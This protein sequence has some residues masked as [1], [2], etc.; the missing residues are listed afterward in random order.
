MMR[1]DGD[2]CCIGWNDQSWSIFCSAQG[3]TAWHKNMPTDI[4][5]PLLSN[6]NRVGVFLDWPAGT[7]SFY[8]FPSVV[9]SRKQIH[10][11]TF[12]CTFS[13]PL[14]PAFGFGRTCEFGTDARL[15]PSSVYLGQIE[16]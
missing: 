2:D 12:H 7:V 15:L 8:C 16:D 9:S 11:H 10:L 13:E 14:Y 3:Y 5:P 1:W 6:G 4:T